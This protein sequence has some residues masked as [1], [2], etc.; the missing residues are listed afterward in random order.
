[1]DD[2][3]RGSASV[4]VV[5]RTAVTGRLRDVLCRLRAIGEVVPEIFFKRPVP[6]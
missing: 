6:L 2:I 1:M 5:V 3:G 4:L